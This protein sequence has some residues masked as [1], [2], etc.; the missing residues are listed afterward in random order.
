M[1]AGAR[2]LKEDR[3]EQARELLVISL[4]F[5]ESNREASKLI[6]DTWLAEGNYQKVKIYYTQALGKL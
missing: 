6:G 1:T 2:L 5:D 3:K 4:R